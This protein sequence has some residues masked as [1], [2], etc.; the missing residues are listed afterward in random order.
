VLAVALDE[1]S[2]PLTSVNEDEKVDREGNHLLETEIQFVEGNGVDVIV[3]HPK[4]RPGRCGGGRG[5]CIEEGAK[6][7]ERRGGHL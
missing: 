1:M 3:T 4:M 5:E 7:S 6:S 2:S